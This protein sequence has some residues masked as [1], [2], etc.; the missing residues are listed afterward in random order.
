MNDVLHE[1]GERRWN[2]EPLRHRGQGPSK[3]FSTGCTRSIPAVMELP[4]L[5]RGREPTMA[6]VGLAQAGHEIGVTRCSANGSTTGI[7]SCWSMFVMNLQ[8][9]TELTISFQ[10]KS[11]RS[12][13][14]STF[15]ERH[16]CL[17][18]ESPWGTP[19]KQHVIAFNPHCDLCSLCS[20]RLRRAATRQARMRSRSPA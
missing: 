10:A 1:G 5:T 3:R 12:S 19:M 20:A 8:S 4:C 13:R 15:G 6:G 2:M 18:I 17:E 7:T 14:R 16:P 11:S 9:T